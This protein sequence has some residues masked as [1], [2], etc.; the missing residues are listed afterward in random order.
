MRKYA[1]YIVM[2]LLLTAL[3]TGCAA[4]HANA[5]GVPSGD[6]VILDNS[7]DRTAHH[8]Q[9]VVTLRPAP[10]PE[11]TPTPAPT[12]TPSPTPAPT[13]E[14]TPE[15]TA[16]PEVSGPENP[17]E[18]LP[19][20]DGKICYLTFDDGPS[21]NTEA[22]LKVLEEKNVVATFF[23]IGNNAQSHPERI[24]AIAAQGSLVAN[25]TQSHDTD[26]IYKS[27]SALLKDLE[28]GRQTILSILGED[29]PDDLMRFPYGSTNRRCRDYRDA[30]RDAGY[31][32]FDWNALNGDAESNASSR[33][34]QDLY[35]QLK[36]TV[37]SQAK[38]GR[39]LIVL[40]H[41]TNSKGKT[42]EMLPDAIDY[43]RSL[44]YTFATLENKPM[45]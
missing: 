6:M 20:V 26:N 19:V 28:A 3:L 7:G 27:E 2:L 13:P 22:I 43:I 36:E 15:P 29:Y 16:T 32:Y 42:V 33:S 9:V 17:A 44:G 30:V 40:M 4:P 45:E 8:E 35:E 37:N 23:V 39:N 21:K 24:E 1:F 38:R 25:H 14:I 31:R 41:D 12:A 18:P 5:Q 10:T 34:A 11:A